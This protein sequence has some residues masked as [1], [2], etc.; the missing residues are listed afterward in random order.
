MTNLKLDLDKINDKLRTMSPIERILWTKE[1]FNNGLYALSSGGIDSA[2]LLDHI[3]KSKQQIPV[4]HIN[5]GFLPKET[6]KFM[7]ALKKKYGFKLIEFSPS[8]EQIAEITLLRLWDGDLDLYSKLTKVEPMSRAVNELG[9]IAL[10]TAVRAD[11]TKNRATLSYVGYGND[12]ELRI[13]PFIDWTKKEVNNYIDK[14][15]LPRNPLYKKGFESV[16]DVYTTMPGLDRN[17][18]LL[19]ECGIHVANGEPLKAK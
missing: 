1:T 2:L 5:T 19:M 6:I 11:Q 4:L 16:G 18:R 8:K 9:V 13:R 3:H 14:N 12:G 17:G 7:Q 15:K 10:L